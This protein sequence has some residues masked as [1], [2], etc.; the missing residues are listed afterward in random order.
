[1]T[2]GVLDAGF[3][4]HSVLI[5]MRWV[6]FV[7]FSI[8]IWTTAEE[9]MSTNPDIALHLAVIDDADHVSLFPNCAHA[10]V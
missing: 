10:S 5:G 3:G 8:A 6:G 7:P 1:M 2:I 4:R 9:R